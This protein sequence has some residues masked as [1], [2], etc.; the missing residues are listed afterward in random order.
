M[1][2]VRDDQVR[3]RRVYQDIDDVT[4]WRRPMKTGRELAQLYLDVDQV[5]FRLRATRTRIQRL[6]VELAERSRKTVFH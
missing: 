6:K 3:L 5:T 1:A 2:N 4:F